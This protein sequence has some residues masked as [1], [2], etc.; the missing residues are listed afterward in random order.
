VFQR[1]ADDARFKRVKVSGDIWKLGHRISGCI[2]G[3]VIG[4]ELVKLER[5]VGFS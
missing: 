2:G 4:N 1:L 3:E 5:L